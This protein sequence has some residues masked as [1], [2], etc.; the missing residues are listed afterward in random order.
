M[1]QSKIN[2]HLL[3][4]FLLVISFILI[5]AIALMYADGAHAT[6]ESSVKSVATTFQKIALA[7]CVVS[8]SLGGVGASFGA[9]W[10]WRIVIGTVLG[11]AFILG[12]PGIIN[13]LSTQIR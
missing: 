7:L 8:A 10:G 5:G 3:E 1:R 13:Y 2:F 12:G 6:V 4:R 11:A 9:Q